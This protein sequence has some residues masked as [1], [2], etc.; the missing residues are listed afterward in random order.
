MLHPP[1]HTH[2]PPLTLPLLGA[3]PPTGQSV[4]TNP[5]AMAERKMQFMHYLST[6][7][8]YHSFK[9]RLKPKIQRVARARYGARGQALG[10]TSSRGLSAMMVPAAE[11]HPSAEERGLGLGLAGERERESNSSP[12]LTKQVLLL[13]PPLPPSFQ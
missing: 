9:E 7:G 8:V 3:P 5:D 1:T 6:S 2:T 12:T 4:V 11:V 13:P 10:R